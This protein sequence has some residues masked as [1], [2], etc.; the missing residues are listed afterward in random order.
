[1][2]VPV[3]HF[4][5]MPSL[6]PGLKFPADLSD[7]LRHDPATGRLIHKGFMSKADFDRLCRLSDDWSFRRPLEDLFRLCGPEE[8]KRSFLARLTSVLGP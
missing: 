2:G 3:E 1:M 4:V 8:P 7:R 6:P 5:T